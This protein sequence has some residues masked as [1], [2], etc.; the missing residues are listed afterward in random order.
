VIPVSSFF[1]FF[2][3]SFRHKPDRE[4]NPLLYYTHLVYVL[5]SQASQTPDTPESEVVKETGTS[6]QNT[7]QLADNESHRKRLRYA[8][9]RHPFLS[10]LAITSLIL[11]FVLL[12][13]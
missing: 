2:C 4:N 1:W 10:A 7:S 5:F 9:A 11:V 6:A 13:L 12:P 3:F 8:A